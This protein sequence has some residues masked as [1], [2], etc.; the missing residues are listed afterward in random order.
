MIMNI[1]SYSTFF[2]SNFLKVDIESDFLCISIN[3]FSM[4]DSL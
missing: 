2:I 4:M 1:F 3:F